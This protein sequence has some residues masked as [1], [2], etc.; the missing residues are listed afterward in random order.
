MR[1]VNDKGELSP[2]EFDFV[3][4][5]LKSYQHET[6]GLRFYD[7]ST[8]ELSTNNLRNIQFLLDAGKIKNSICIYH[9]GYYNNFYGC[10]LKD[11]TITN[12]QT[13][14]ELTL[15]FDYF[16]VVEDIKS[17]RKEKLKRINEISSS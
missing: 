2:G 14:I 11:Y 1:I 16:E 4:M 7:D 6:F 5:E 12:L 8:L 15:C 3:K 17:Q 10:F 13:P 9:D